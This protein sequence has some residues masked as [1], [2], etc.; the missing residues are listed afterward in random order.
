VKIDS[1]GLRGW[2][3]AAVV[4]IATTGFL[5]YSPA[6]SGTVS[7]LPAIVFA[8][9]LSP[10]PGLYLAVIVLLTAMGI[11]VSSYAER[12]FQRK[13]PGEVTIDEVVGMLIALYGFPFTPFVVL[14]V[15]LLYRVFDILKPFPARQF[16]SLPVGFGIMADDI[17]AGFYANIF[18]HLIVALIQILSR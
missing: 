15:F 12:F 16:E 9:L 11:A 10:Y 14:A 7:S 13:D 1:L 18:I 8:F 17:V 6:A 3:D 4:F 2:K 5:G